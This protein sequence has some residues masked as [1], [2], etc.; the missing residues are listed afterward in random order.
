[1]KLSALFAK[2][3]YQHKELKLPGIGIFSLDPSLPVP[4]IADKNF[5]D[6][7]KHIR[8][9]QVP[10]TAADDDFIN[11]IRTETGKIRPLAESDLDSFLSDGKILLNIGK[12]FHF[13]GIGY[14]QK[15]KEGTYEFTAGEPML[16]RLEIF[17]HESND[18][19]SKNKPFFQK[20]I[21]K[22]MRSEK[23]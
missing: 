11:F 5:S 10:V 13:E 6:F 16:Q 7:L 1:M 2:F 17:S 19:A 23:F 21:Y 22:Q 3:L 12:P 9:R 8:Y 14:L 4:D 20:N 18:E 15:N